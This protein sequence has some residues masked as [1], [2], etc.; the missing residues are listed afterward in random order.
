MSS[1]SDLIVTVISGVIY[2]YIGIKLS[3]VIL[4]FISAAGGIILMI[5]QTNNEYSIASMLLVAKLGVGGTFNLVFISNSHLYPSVLA[6]TSFGIC[7]VF[8]RLAT[9][10]AP[11]V[12]ELDKVY[13]NLIFAI[14]ALVAA[15]L[16]MFIIA[17]NKK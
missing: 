12:A 15:I 1:A 8:A 13:S 17:P 2:Y 5:V 14:F 6:S 7:N 9:I 3:F 10:A 11:I 16:S 4:F